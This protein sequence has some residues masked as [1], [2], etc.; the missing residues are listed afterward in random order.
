MKKRKLNIKGLIALAIISL[1]FII[2]IAAI[3]DKIRYEISESEANKNYQLIIN[4][5]TIEANKIIS[6]NNFLFNH[7]NKEYVKVQMP[8]NSVINLQSKYNL[9]DSN[10]EIFSGEISYLPDGKYTLKMKNGNYQYIYYLEVDN[11]FSIEIDETYAKQGGFIVASFI[12][13][14]SDEEVTIDSEFKTSND[15]LFNKDATVLPI[16]YSNEAKEYNIVFSSD[17]SKTSKPV[18]IQEATHSNVV[19]YWNDYEVKKES[20]SD[21]YKAFKKAITTAS[22]DKLYTNFYTPTT[23]NV[24]TNFGDQFFINNEAEPSIINLALDY[25][26]VLNTPVYSTSKGVVVYAGELEVAGK[27]V[28]VDHGH[29]IVSTYSHLNEI[30]VEVGTPVTNDTTIG[31][32]GE[33]GNVRGVHLNFEILINGIKVDPNIFLF[34]DLNF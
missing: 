3:I 13:L 18:N 11:D 9:V 17:K 27:V 25:S 6:K 28:V 22:E 31:K 33:S 21:E 8:K 14:N 24:I 15:Y 10:G 20:D 29:G 4:D 19:L 34:S 12:D 32:M 2:I 5:Q 16:D 7:Y 1:L 23:G 26:N 30:T